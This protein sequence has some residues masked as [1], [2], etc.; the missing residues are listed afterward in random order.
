VCAQFLELCDERDACGRCEERLGPVGAG[1]VWEVQYTEDETTDHISDITAWLWL[2]KTPAPGQSRH[3]AAMT[4]R[5]GLAWPIWGRLSLAHGLRPRAV[6]R[7]F[8]GTAVQTRHLDGY[9]YYH[10]WGVAKVL[11]N[12]E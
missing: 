1:M 3:E 6:H 5:L 10:V 12:H 9:G 7:Q 2:L 4:A 8:T 11:P